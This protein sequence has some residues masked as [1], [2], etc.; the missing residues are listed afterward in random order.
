MHADMA[1]LRKRE[2]SRLDKAGQVYLDYTGGGLYAESQIRTHTDRLMNGVF[3]NPHSENPASLA[4]T[5]HVEAARDRI[6]AF[7]DADPVEYEVIFTANA[8]GALKLIGESYPFETDSRYTLIADNHNSVNGIREFATSKGAVIDYIPLNRYLRVDTSEVEHYLA[9]TDPG[10][11]NLFAY[12]AQ[13]NFSG[14]KHPLDWIERA[15][16]AG[17][18]VL[19]DA[20][21]Y[22]PTS[23]LHLS[24]TKP[25]FVSLSFY[26]M[27]GFPTGVGALIARRET[28]LKLR[29]PWFAGGT[30][31]FASAQNQMHLLQATG[32]AFEDGTLNYLSIA[33]VTTGLDFLE[34]VGMERINQHVAD[35]TAV[36]LDRLKALRH[37]SGAP[38]IQ[39]YGPQDMESRGGTVSI[40]LL[41]PDGSLIDSKLVEQR[42]NAHSISIRS[43][44]FCNPGS[45]E[46]AFNYPAEESYQC[47]TAIKPET[48]TLQ[49]FS[50]CMHD[51]PVGAV[52]I[53]MGI[54]TNEA[55]INHLIDLLES[56]VD[57]TPPP[58]YARTPPEMVG[59]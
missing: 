55:D 51:M 56:F 25:D 5:H 47:F 4:S 34:S 19:L 7:F 8:S 6:R 10:K 31:R 18:D 2:F 53:S 23:P 57:F 59:G 52:R 29:R 44:C 33:A 3:G 28:L 1:D 43:G 21:A 41:D 9:H 30:V 49:Q 35:L 26:K 27:F 11:D 12:P 15:K 38:L 40:N 16:A 45:A 39:I 54:A 32:E 22:V 42:A 48:F 14:I 24:E 46:T 50:A 17:Y 20:A 58:D 37:S 36:L 13:S